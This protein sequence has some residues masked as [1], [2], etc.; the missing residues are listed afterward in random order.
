LLAE[1][2][3]HQDADP[4]WAGNDEGGVGGDAACDVDGEQTGESGPVV[5]GDAVYA[6]GDNL[7]RLEQLGA[8]PMVKTQP[9]VAGAGRFTKDDF[10]VDLATATVTCPA[11]A[12]A[13]IAVHGDANGVASFGAH[14]HQ[15]PLRDRC[16]SA[17]E[18]RGSE[19]AVAEPGRVGGVGRLEGGGPAGADLAGRVVVHGGGRVQADAGVVVTM[20]VVVEELEAQKSRACWMEPN[21]AGKAGQY[22]NVLKFASE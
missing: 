9:A 16:T 1:F 17:K 14:C 20:V 2:A 21:R 22:F 8:K 5:Y 18:L 19:A 4:G 3:H 10:T 6:S 12:T 13:V 11:Q 15:C 7:E